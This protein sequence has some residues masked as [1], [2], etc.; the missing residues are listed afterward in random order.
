MCSFCVQLGFGAVATAAKRVDDDL[1]LA[2]AKALHGCVTCQEF[3][4]GR[5]YPDM[6]VGVWRLHRQCQVTKC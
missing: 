6:K 2:A 3:E 4:E 5:I 1:L